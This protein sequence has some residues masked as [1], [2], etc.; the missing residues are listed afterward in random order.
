MGFGT[1]GGSNPA[2]VILPPDVRGTENIV[3]FKYTHSTTV[4]NIS[5]FFRLFVLKYGL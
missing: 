4:E 3:V 1:R 2:F 5:I